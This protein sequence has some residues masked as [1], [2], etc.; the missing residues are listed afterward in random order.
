MT[1]PP[2]DPHDAVFAEIRARA[3]D[4]RA[5]LA[6]ASQ[7][8][9]SSISPK[10]SLRATIS[11]L[12]QMTTR[13][14]LEGGVALAEAPGALLQMIGA[15]PQA[16]LTPQ[17]QGISGAAQWLFDHTTLR[18]GPRVFAAAR[19]AIRTRLGD[20]KTEAG[21]WGRLGMNAATQV[22]APVGLVKL[23]GRVLGALRGGSRGPNPRWFNPRQPIAPPPEAPTVRPANLTPGQTSFLDDLAGSARKTREPTP[24]ELI[25]GHQET[26]L[27]RPIPSGAPP[28]R[29]VGE[30][31]Y[32]TGLGPGSS[33]LPLTPQRTRT[34][35]SR[36]LGVDREKISILP[37]KPPFRGPQ[38]PP[39]RLPPDA[40]R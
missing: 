17:M 13:G 29:P 16:A 7:V 34:L 18:E 22:V 37:P 26:K 12:N 30:T 25:I 6:D 28:V 33:R 20:P 27:G 19:E 31:V 38:P 11:D 36:V 35:L 39:S 23:G 5:S 21:R 24:M 10:P 3:R 14:M 2:L 15:A 4:G 32:P 1:G 9:T 8:N 40:W